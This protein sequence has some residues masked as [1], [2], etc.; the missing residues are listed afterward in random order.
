[1]QL[2]IHVI[3]HHTCKGVK[4]TNLRGIFVKTTVTLLHPA[5]FQQWVQVKATP[6]QADMCLMDFTYTRDSDNHI[7]N[8]HIKNK[9]VMLTSGLFTLGQIPNFLK[10]REAVQDKWYTRHLFK[11]RK[12]AN[13]LAVYSYRVV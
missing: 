2:I 4:F 11:Y 12:Y 5:V 8:K 13:F 3:S 6:C 9:T 10:C 7:N 1:M